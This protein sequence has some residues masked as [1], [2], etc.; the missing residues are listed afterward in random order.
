MVDYKNII[1]Y[2][3]HVN[4][5]EAGGLLQQLFTS[6]IHLLAFLSKYF[7]LLHF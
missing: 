4:M 3:V 1:L 6:N 5:N 7:T 2:V